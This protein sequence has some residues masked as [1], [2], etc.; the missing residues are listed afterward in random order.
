[1]KKRHY[2]PFA[3][4]EH[5][6]HFLKPLDVLGITTNFKIGYC[7]LPKIKIFLFVSGGVG[8]I[9]LWTHVRGRLAERPHIIII[10]SLKK[11]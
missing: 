8:I 6:G 1:M 3:F 4:K 2:T 9:Q 11:K 7:N 5:I 10:L